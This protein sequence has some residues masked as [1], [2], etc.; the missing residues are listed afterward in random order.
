MSEIRAAVA[1]TCSASAC[2]CTPWRR[3]VSTARNSRLSAEWLAA[4]GCL[5]CQCSL[6]RWRWRILAID[7]RWVTRHKC[8]VLGVGAGR[9]LGLLCAAV[10]MAFVAK[11]PEAGEDG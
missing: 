5:R 6:L 4:N 8:L 7:A 2:C 9:D 1:P 10:G 3:S 11:V